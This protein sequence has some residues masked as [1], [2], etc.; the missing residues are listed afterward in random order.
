MMRYIALVV[1]LFVSFIAC[2]TF[3]Q[4][5]T[6]SNQKLT[7]K[8]VFDKCKDAI[9]QIKTDT[10]TGTGFLVGD[11]KQSVAFV[12]TCYHVVSGA[13]SL[14]VLTNNGKEIVI[15]KIA[16]NRDGDAALIVV[17][18]LRGVRPLE[19]VSTNDLSPGDD[20]FVIG[21]PLG[22]LTQTITTGILSSKRQ[23]GDRKY[24]QI[25]A[26]VSH[27]SSGSPILNSYGQA[28]GFVSFNFKEGQS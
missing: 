26:P 17:E 15:K 18:P 12:I 4:K 21:N 11:P 2:P 22:F 23:V 7:A 14:K 13:K 10:G 16:V 3:A 8:Q 19:S 24:L 20:I 9:V 1:A 5:K 28:V 27:G 6:P 25:T